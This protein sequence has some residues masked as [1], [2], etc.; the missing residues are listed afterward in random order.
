[1]TLYE[2]YSVVRDEC[3]YTDYQVA[4]K[5]GINFSAIYDWKYGR[6]KPKVEKMKKIAELLNI[7]LEELVE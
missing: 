4:T 2:K 7:P 3:G 1:M 6:S 5:C